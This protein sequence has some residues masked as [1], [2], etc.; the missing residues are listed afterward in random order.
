MWAEV[1]A[2]VLDI[3]QARGCTLRWLC[4]IQGS[5]LCWGNR[6]FTHPACCV[7]FATGDSRRLTAAIDVA[8]EAG[9]EKLLL[10]KARTALQASRGRAVALQAGTS[11]LCM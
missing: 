6:L 4:L 10:K 8:D 7:R 11:R 1:A 9:V 2:C 5:G 3:Q